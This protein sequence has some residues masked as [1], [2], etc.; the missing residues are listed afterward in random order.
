MDDNI[1]KFLKSQNG[2]MV[3]VLTFVHSIQLGK[4]FIVE[5]ADSFLYP[6]K[7]LNSFT[8]ISKK[9]FLKY[10]DTRGSVNN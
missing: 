3:Y 1:G 2:R 9:E 4:I 10:A 8:E 5:D 6:L 7:T